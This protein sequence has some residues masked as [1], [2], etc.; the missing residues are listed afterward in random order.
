MSVLWVF[1]C[2]PMWD[3]GLIFVKTGPALALARSWKVDLKK[4]SSSGSELRRRALTSESR[5][6]F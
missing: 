2:V 3:R 5:N 4:V 1:D 6:F